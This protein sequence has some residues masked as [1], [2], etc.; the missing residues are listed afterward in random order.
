MQIKTYLRLSVGFTLAFEG[1][2]CGHENHPMQTKTSLALTP[3]MDIGQ[4]GSGDKCEFIF[5]HSVCAFR[6]NNAVTDKRQPFLVAGETHGMDETEN[7]K[8]H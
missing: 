1:D 7:G 4:T 5:L 8:R 3:S 2:K 6:T